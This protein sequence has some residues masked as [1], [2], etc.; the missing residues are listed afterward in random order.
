MTEFRH[1]V[2]QTMVGFVGEL[3]VACLW[4]IMF[5]FKQ[6]KP[7]SFSNTSVFIFIIPGLCDLIDTTTFNVGMTQVSP[8]ITT[9]VRSMTSP[10]SAIMSYYLVKSKLSCKQIIAITLVISGVLTACFVQ[11]FFETKQEEFVLTASGLV[12]LCISSMFN[13]LQ[14]VIE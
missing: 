5:M 14:A 9:M 8:S 7:I 3:F 1:P 2:F 11:L 12:I 4:A 10:A 13:A 6:G